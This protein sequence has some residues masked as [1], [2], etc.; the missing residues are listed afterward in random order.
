M[1]RIKLTFRY[2]LSRW[3]TLLSVIGVFLGVASLVVTLAVMSGFAKEVRQ[4]LRGG[5]SDVIIDCDVAGFP[6]YDDFVAM[7]LTNPNVA[8]ATP[9][10]QLYGIVTIQAEG[11]E[12]REAGF[13]G[14][15]VSKPCVIYGIQPI[16]AAKVN[17]F[18]EY[19]DR[20]KGFSAP[21]LD[22]PTAIA[23][24]LRSEG[25]EVFPGCIPGREMVTYSP[26]HQGAKPIGAPSDVVL[27]SGLGSKLVLNTVQISPTGAFSTIGGMPKLGQDGFTV[28]DYYKSR[29]FEFDSKYVYVPFDRAQKLGGLD[30]FTAADGRVFPPRAHQVLVRLRDYGKAKETIAEITA[31]W[32]QLCEKHWELRFNSMTFLTWEQRQATALGAVE[33]QRTLMVILLA[34]IVLVAGFLIG[35]VLSMIVK[36]KTRDIG[37]LKSLGASNFGVAQIFLFYGG[38][39]SSVGALLGLAAGLTIIHYLDPIEA[40]VSK[41]VGFNLFPREVFYFD[42]IPRDVDPLNTTL[43][44]VSAIALA[45]LCSTVAAWRAARLPPVEALRYE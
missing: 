36:E 15:K 41:T 38:F 28:V 42:H 13:D 12:A 44:V 24:D 43:V 4:A 18:S 32:K 8:E 37:I 45:V 22:V 7:I 14:V 9:V 11:R 19:L 35:A 27:L 26:P 5:L 34:L 30:A 40:W 29:V 21:T 17:K 16:Q 23:E 31:Q 6:Y 39:V 2:I 25:R 3:L 33:V 1:Y 20:Q 10:V